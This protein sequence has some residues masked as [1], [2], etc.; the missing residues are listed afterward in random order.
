MELIHPHSASAPGWDSTPTLRVPPGGGKDEYRLVEGRLEFRPAGRN[1][2]RQLDYPEIQ[3]H[4][5]LGTAVAKWIA[6][7]YTIAKLAQ[8]LSS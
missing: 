4:M 1:R 7:L 2:W 6:E 5:V 8:V 3:Q